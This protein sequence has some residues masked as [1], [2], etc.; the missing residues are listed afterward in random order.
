MARREL[1]AAALQVSR[2]VARMWPGGRVV[3]GVSGGADS[4][5]LAAGA[6]WCAR[7]QGGEVLAVIVDHGLQPGSDEVSARVAQQLLDRGIPTTVRPVRVAGAGGVEAAARRARLAALESFGS[8]V[9]LGHTLDDQAEQVFL[10]LLRGSGLR[11]LAGIP[12][13]RGVF[14]R[15]L[16]GIRRATT[17]AAV[18]QWGLQAWEDPMNSDERFRR[19]QVRGW[20]ADFERALGRDV[21]ANLAR[22]AQLARADADLLDELAGPPPVGEPLPLSRLDCHP[23]LRERRIK[24]WLSANG[25]RPTQV[26]VSEVARLVSAWRGQGPIDVPGG[27]VRRSGAGL[28]LLG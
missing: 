5:A 2:A 9:L 19:V 25:C 10:G 11:S 14:L 6:E 1:G 15:P 22:T 20:L 8:P 16:L 28:E 21:R 13:R 7:R 4:L 23:A 26:H 27:R 3:V 12:E 17:L 18:A 24:A